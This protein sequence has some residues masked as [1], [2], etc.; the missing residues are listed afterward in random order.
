MVSEKDLDSAE[1]ETMRISM[2][3]DDGNDGQRRGANE[4]RS[5]G[6]C[7]A[8]GLFRQSCISSR[9][10]RSAFSVETLRGTWAHVSSGK[11]VRNHISS[12]MA[13]ELISIYFYYVPFMV[14]G[15]PASSSSITPSSASS[16]SA[17]Q[18]STS[19]NSDSVSENRDVEAPVSE[20][21]RGVNE[22]LRGDPLHDSTETENQNK[23][24]ESKEVQRDISH[25][26]PDWPHELREN[27]VDEST[28]EGRREDLMQRRVF[29]SS[30]SHRP[31]AEPRCAY[32]VLVSTVYLRTFCR[33]QN[34]N[35]CF[36]V[37]NN[38]GFLQKRRRRSRAT[39]GTYRRLDHCRSQSSKWRKW[40]EEQSPICF[41]GTRLGNPPPLPSPP[42]EL[43][44]VLGADKETKSHLHWHFLGIWQS[45]WRSFLESL[46]VDTTQIRNKW[47]CWKSS[48]QCKRRH[49]C[50]IVAIRSG[51]KLV[52]RVHG[53]LTP[54]CE[55]FTDLLSD[56]KTP[57]W[58]T[59][60]ETIW[61]TDHSVWLTGWASPHNCERPVKNP[62]SWKEILT[63]IVPWIRFVR[64][65]YLEG[66]RTGC[67]HWGVGND[68]RIGNLLKKTQCK[69]TV[70]ATKKWKLHILCSRSTNKIRWRR[71]GTENIQL[72][73]ASTQF[74]ETVR[75][76]FLEQK[77][78]HL[79]HLKTHIWMPVKR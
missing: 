77:G 21:N 19:E 65:G 6:M 5:D 10:S 26:L 9:N 8:L 56:G 1:L 12:K 79:H 2:E 7:Q 71:S 75:E 54:I 66:W 72:G 18:E 33:V 74:E 45:L 52:G 20:R 48:A 17:S 60:W 47:D 62:S 39:S 40:I 46:Y 44:E 23:N 16:P 68:G 43:N 38:K 49:L 30:S 57:I 29:T 35:I 28:S 67:R 25:E 14:P 50:R 76:I 63:W 34:V 55:T 61:R 32:L 13:S 4:W 27:V 78:L 36:D 24:R 3:S 59:F 15:I 51:W 69:G 64:G 22:E 70:N 11:A 58:G 53:M 42:E 41:G 31:P 73:T 37:Q